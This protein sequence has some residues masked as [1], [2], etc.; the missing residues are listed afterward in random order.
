M[1][2]TRSTTKN[3]NNYKSQHNTTTASIAIL[4]NIK[5]STF[6]Y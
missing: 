1:A 5:D 6:P 3:L 2:Q 4:S